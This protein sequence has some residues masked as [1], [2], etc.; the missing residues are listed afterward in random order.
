MKIAIW[1]RTDE[2]GNIRIRTDSKYEDRDTPRIC[3][4]GNRLLNAI[5]GNREEQDN[6]RKPS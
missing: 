1:I 4:V 3:A 2:H 5:E 6:E